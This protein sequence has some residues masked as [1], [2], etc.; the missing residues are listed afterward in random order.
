MPT[1]KVP[2]KAVPSGGFT[3][4]KSYDIV[5]LSLQKQLVYIN[6]EAGIARL[7]GPDGGVIARWGDEVA[8]INGSIR[9]DRMIGDSDGAVLMGGK[10]HDILQ[11][12]GFNALGSKMFGGVGN[13]KLYLYSATGSKAD[14]G[15]GNDNFTFIDRTAGHLISGGAGMDSVI[16]RDTDAAT[17]ERLVVDLRHGTVLSNGTQVASISG[18]ENF[19]AGSGN[20]F[21]YGDGNDNRLSGGEGNDKLHGGRGNDKLLGG[22][23]DDFLNGGYGNDVMNGGRG[24]DYF[25][26]GYDSDTFQFDLL[27]AGEVDTISIFGR[28]DRLD[29]RG[30]VDSLDDLDI[31]IDTS[32]PS[33]KTATIS[34]EVGGG[35]H[36]IVIEKLLSTMSLTDD[37][38]QHALV[39]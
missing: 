31:A 8:R 32:N 13:D 39:G 1:Y 18:I 15:E 36:T 11:D 29:F 27:T 34:I 37:L 28:S 22:D 16:Y 24:N 9:N 30:A 38:A 14:G 2:A 19:Y 5:D 12:G 21:I 20:D 10:G 35:V 23:G 25:A 33:H 6:A 26:A 17:T 3:V 4:P 7:G